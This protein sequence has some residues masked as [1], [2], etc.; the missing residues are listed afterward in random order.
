MFG[1]N[2]FFLIGAVIFYLLAND[3]KGILQES[4]NKGKS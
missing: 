4:K 3:W 1:Q 2:D